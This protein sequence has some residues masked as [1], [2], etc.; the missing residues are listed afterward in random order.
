MNTS[1][2]LRRLKDELRLAAFLLDRIVGLNRDRAI[3]I[4]V[5]RDTSPKHRKISAIDRSRQPRQRQQSN[6]EKALKFGQLH[7]FVIGHRFGYRWGVDQLISNSPV[8]S[9]TVYPDGGWNSA[10][11]GSLVLRFVSF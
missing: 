2:R 11:S 8:S 4:P 5:R 1:L 6:P 10:A 3:R 7:L 9:F